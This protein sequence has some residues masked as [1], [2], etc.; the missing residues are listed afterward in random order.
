[1]TGKC[2]CGAVSVTIERKPDFIHDCNCDLCRKS[3]GAWAYVPAAAAIVVGDTVSFVRR[4]K[5]NAAAAVHSCVRC[6]ATTHW[7]FTE[8]F[9]HDHPEVDL[10]G[11][12]MRLFD[13][14]ALGG[15]EVRFPN[16]KDWAGEGPFDYRRGNATIGDGFAW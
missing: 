4:D 3:G 8:R 6:A 5:P 12:N 16:G 11:V 13:P 2:L 1:M 9:S 15:V 10:M 7:V 14:A